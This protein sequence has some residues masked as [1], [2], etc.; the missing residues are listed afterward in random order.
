MNNNNQQSNALAI[1]I[2]GERFTARFADTEAAREFRSRLPLTIEMPD[3]NSNEKHAQLSSS[4]P[5]NA[6]NPG[7]IETGDLMLYGSSTLVLF[8]KSFNTSYTYTR[9]ATMDNPER[10]AQVVG[11]GTVTVQFA[12]E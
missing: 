3:L 10:L 4:L 1:T 5:T 11:S 6:S 8:Y 12:T 2:N 7:R 9:L